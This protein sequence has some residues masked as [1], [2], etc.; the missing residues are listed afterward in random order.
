M[1]YFELISKINTKE[2]S[3]VEETK[4]SKEESEKKL[5]DKIGMIALIYAD[6][7][8]QEIK[9]TNPNYKFSEAL[10]FFSPLKF[11]ILKPIYNL[12]D[13]DLKKYQPAIDL[14]MES[15]YSEVDLRRDEVN[16]NLDLIFNLV[17][18]RRNDIKK[19]LQI[20]NLKNN[21]EDEDKK[22]TKIINFG[23]RKPADALESEDIFDS[24]EK[25]GFSENNEFIEVHFENFYR[26]GQEKLGLDLIKNDFS[27]I[28]ENILDEKPQTAAIIG[29][30]WLLDSPMASYLGFKNIEE[31]LRAKESDEER[32]EEEPTETVK[33]IEEENDFPT[34][35]Q[36][37]DKNDEINQR[38]FDK[39]LESG[40]LPFKSVKA[41]IPVEDFLRRYL[42]ASRRGKITLKKASPE[43]LKLQ[44]EKQKENKIIREKWTELIKGQ[45]SYE[46][47]IM[48]PG[49][50]YLLTYLNLEDGHKFL[51]FFKNMYDKKI[52]VADFDEYKDENMKIIFKK[53]REKNDD[54]LYDRV[55][56]II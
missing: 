1:K 9:V 49:F 28:A 32:L 29:N 40:K 13:F 8:F 16:F 15:F 35:F 48:S 12:A 22:I 42:P 4:E 54:E 44:L 56:L 3:P 19:Y 25:L 43:K 37:V 6:R 20:E 33:P 5:L 24:L 18:K 26:S 41:Y 27:E 14:F 46:D 21:E 45:G 51:D 11:I 52:D 31:E 34:W 47:Y 17:D 30:S 36:F 10:K 23:L 55:E 39:F 50:S 38:R 53:I 7:K 2:K